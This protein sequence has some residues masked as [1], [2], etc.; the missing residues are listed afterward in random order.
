MRGRIPDR[1]KEPLADPIRGTGFSI[2]A[3]AATHIGL[4]RRRNEDA[5]L[6]RGEIGLF[7]VADGVGGGD[8]G[9]RASRLIVESL[10]R[11][12]PPAGYRDFVGEV[13]TALAEVNRR[14]RV[15]AAALGSTRSIAST[16]VVLLLFDR[17]FCCLWA[18]DSRI[19]RLQKGRFERLTR[20]HSEVER[21]LERGLITA[22]EARRHPLA[23]MITRAVGADPTLALDAVEG[24]VEAGDAFLLCSDG[25]NR[26]VADGEIERVLS[27]HGAAE[28][29]NVLIQATLA[30]GAPDNVSVL[31]VKL[32]ACDPHA[33]G[34]R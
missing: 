4:V 29:V 30:G 27:R 25:L 3:A 1:T 6:E 19:Y 34:D 17:S 13:R 24:G 12:R 18:G 23:N 2:D 20:D 32:R 33:S 22:E 5:I 14:L 9:D 11:I 21:L 28:V 10:A 26:V 31:A 8:A 7:A 16:V 15:E